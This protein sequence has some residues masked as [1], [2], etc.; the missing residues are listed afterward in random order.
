MDD[1]IHNEGKVAEVVAQNQ[2]ATIFHFP[3]PI[4]IIEKSEFIFKVKEVAEE[5]LSKRRKEQKLND[6]YPVYMSDNLLDARLNDFLEFSGSTAWNILESQGYA[7]NGFGTTFTE[8]W[9]QEHYKHSAMEQHTHNGNVQIVGFYFLDVP[10]ESSKAVFHDPRPAK[11][12]L[13]LPEADVNIATPAS[14]MIN[15]EPKPGMFIFSNAWL[16]HSFT[17]HGSKKPLR[18]VHF[19]IAVQP[20]LQSCQVPPPAEVI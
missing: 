1:V 17:R 11:V 19:N 10:K 12:Q 2:L 14:Q 3:S 6:L 16:P 7:M 18:F 4:Y 20:A 5:S 8:I 13:N 9:V 15:F